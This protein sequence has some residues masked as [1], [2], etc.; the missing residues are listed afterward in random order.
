MKWNF[1]VDPPFYVD[2]DTLIEG[3]S[4]S[5]P[6]ILGEMDD[7]ANDV[8]G[9]AFTLEYDSSVVVPGSAKMTFNNGWVGS[10][11]VDMITIQKTFISPGVIDVGMTRI[12]GEEMDGFGEIGQ[13]FITIEDDILFRNGEDESRNGDELEVIFNISN[14]KI[15]NSLGEEIPINPIETS[16]V[17]DGIV[18]TKN[19][20]WK[21]NVQ[22]QPNP[23]SDAFYITSKNI[24]IESI[25]LISITGEALIQIKP[26]GLET[27]I[28]THNLLPGI[29]LLKVQTEFGVM[30]KRMIIAK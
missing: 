1:T 21:E 15:I 14:V 7:P 22:V 27:Q 20:A 2:P 6:V 24:N 13:V 12:D 19:I 4:I 11:G 10:K 26:N 9:I 16:T 18:G 29:Y 8:Y 23:A 3:E 30:V 5:L 28:D 25:N 17:I